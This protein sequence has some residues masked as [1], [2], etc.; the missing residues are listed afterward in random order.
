ME[1]QRSKAENVLEI[2]TYSVKHCRLVWKLKTE[3]IIWFVRRGKEMGQGFQI[4][5]VRVSI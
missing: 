3:L 1:S 5:F 4:K 2:V